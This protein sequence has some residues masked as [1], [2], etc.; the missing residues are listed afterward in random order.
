MRQKHQTILFHSLAAL[1][2]A[3][4]LAR[5]IAISLRYPFYFIWDMDQISALDTLLIGSG[6]IPDHL[7]HTGFGMYLIQ[8]LS[9][10]LA[11]GLHL[12]STISL[13]DMNASL[14]PA[15]GIAELTH[16]L[17][18]HSPFMEILLVVVLWAG[19]NIMLRPG[20]WLSLL[21]LAFIGTQESLIYHASMIRTEL[22]AMFFWSAAL[23]AMAC[24][25]RARRGRDFHIAMTLAGLFLAL[26]FMT[27]VQS[28]FHVVAFVLLTLL[29]F[30]MIDP[31]TSPLRP[32]L[33]ARGVKI[34]LG[35]GYANLAIF[36]LLLLAVIGVKIPSD[37]GTFTDTKGA[38]FAVNPFTLFFG[39]AAAGLAAGQWF[40]YSKKQTGT[41]L[42]RLLNVFTLFFS[43]LLLAFLL[44]FLVFAWPGTSLTYL[45]YDFKMI[46]L[47]EI[48][49]QQKLG[50]IIIDP[51]GFVMYH[52]VMFI[53]HLALLGTLVA[54]WLGRFVSVT[55]KQVALCAALT[56]LAL[57]MLQ[58]A[59]RYFLRDILWEETLIVVLDCYT[60]MLIW[61]GV[62]RNAAIFRL[63]GAAALALALAVAA[64]HGLSMP[65]RIDMN[66]NV[67]GWNA[68]F[69]QH[70]V[71][72]G[73]QL[74]YTAE[75]NRLFN[76]QPPDGGGWERWKAARR[77]ACDEAAILGAA[78]FVFQNQDVSHREVGLVSE[79][80]P[81]WTRQPDVRIAEYSPELKDGIV[82][83]SGALPAKAE[84][85]SKSEYVRKHSEYLDK[86]KPAPG[87][88]VVSILPRT[89]L[90]V[91][92]FLQKED[93]DKIGGAEFALTQDRIVLRQG[94]A[95]VEMVGVQIKEYTEI[96]A[97]AF[98]KGYFYVLKRKYE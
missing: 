51:L 33:G 93:L 15:T 6:Q 2:V 86:S 68:D 98:T 72:R 78:Q 92:L 14:N 10:R 65:R 3:F 16:Y 36:V 87:G 28:F 53:V 59:V 21:F 39:A 18:M 88:G 70:E 49:S 83:D 4:F 5:Y 45:L 94:E 24:G 35:L 25:V 30:T 58:L 52:P 75:M 81:V 77:A 69:W 8:S 55:G 60:L 12:L 7:N 73:N 54:G 17:R 89:D 62:R 47:R 66:C 63:A 85:F 57:A 91:F 32:A 38:A 31:K 41:T 84:W 80:F 90:Q 42:F 50:Y 48:E 46:F 19:L 97:A 71:Y 34:F 13:A 40:L 27:K 43:G 96:P 37:S 76:F 64:A 61:R 82:V 44:H 20:R 23:C 22:Y 1:L 56:L 79:G 95:G 67:Y 11:H 26:C 74:K 29:S 9:A